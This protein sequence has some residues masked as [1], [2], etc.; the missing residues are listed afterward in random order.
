MKIATADPFMV[1]RARE[2]GEG[3]LYIASTVGAWYLIALGV[4][5]VLRWSA[6]GWG[7]GIVLALISAVVLGL[8]LIGH[9]RAV[10]DRV[11]ARELRRWR[12]DAE[13][14][15]SASLGRERA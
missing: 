3:L 7:G 13:A 10:E 8:L 12:E 11:R 9:R 6:W 15:T 14:V 5:H 1:Q 4:A 2:A